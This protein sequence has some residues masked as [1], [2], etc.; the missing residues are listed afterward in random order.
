MH[1]ST[2]MLSQFLTDKCK[3]PKPRKKTAH[4]Y[5]LTDK[6]HGLFFLTTTSLRQC[7]LLQSRFPPPQPPHSPRITHNVVLA[8]GI[9]NSYET[10]TQLLRHDDHR[11]QP[12]LTSLTLTA[13][14]SCPA[15]AI[16]TS[17]AASKPKVRTRQQ[18][19]LS[20]HTI[21]PNWHF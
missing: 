21:C 9:I 2:S 14:E 11:L 7:S 3:Q 17:D 5:F 20:A 16:A 4:F 15:P 18:L 19:A 8:T 13:A 6:P 12:M 10:P 1:R